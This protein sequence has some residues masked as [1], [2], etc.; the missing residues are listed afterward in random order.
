MCTQIVTCIV[1]S[2]P[3]PFPII[4][5]PRTGLLNDFGFRS[6]IEDL[7]FTGSPL[8]IKNIKIGF[9]ERRS[10]FVLD[11]LDTCFAADYLIAG[12]DRSCP[13]DIQADRRIELQCIPPR[14]RFRIT[15]HD[16]DLHTDLIDEYD[17]CIV[18]INAACELSQRL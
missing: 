2:L 7:T 1:F 18:F 9:L 11:D 4:A 10:C 17:G 3:D 5:I 6:Q 13:A 8:S 16:T 15:E 12:F 14:R